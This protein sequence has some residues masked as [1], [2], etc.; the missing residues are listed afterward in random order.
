MKKIINHI[1]KN[2]YKYLLEILVVIV[3]ILIAFTLSNWNESNNRR[4]KENI[5]LTEIH[6]E[7][8]LNRQQLDTAKKQHRQG[9][10]SAKWF[11]D[12]F[13]F[14]DYNR[15]SNDSIAFHLRKTMSNWTFDPSQSTINSIINTS[16]MEL[17]SNP[18]LR[19]D[20]MRWTDTVNDY[21]EEEDRMVAYGF[22]KYLD[23]FSSN[24]NLR[25]LLRERS[26]ENVKPMQTEEFENVMFRRFLFY[27]SI[28]GSKDGEIDEVERL[29][30]EIIALTDLAQE[31]N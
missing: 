5:L 24:Y 8:V 31:T 18:T 21:K 14:N 15:P 17:I 2:W 19:R 11:L 13:P 16:S 27:R 7:F 29:L 25:K 10:N 1:K 30:N 28:V 9:Y 26:L 6:N 4:T 23:F 22:G 3:G 12:H 20:L